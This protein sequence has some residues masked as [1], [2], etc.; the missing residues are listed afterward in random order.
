MTKCWNFLV[1][2]ALTPC[3]IRCPIT[4][5]PLIQAHRKLSP[6]IDLVELRIIYL[7][8]LHSYGHM[9]LPS[10]PALISSIINCVRHIL[11]NCYAFN[12][13]SSLDITH[14]VTHCNII[15]IHSGKF[16]SWVNTMQDALIVTSMCNE[17]Q[18]WLKCTRALT[19]PDLYFSPV[20]AD[21][22]AC[23]ILV[24]NNEKI[25]KI[26]LKGHYV[27]VYFGDYS[28]VPIY[29]YAANPLNVLHFM[30]L[31]TDPQLIEKG[32]AHEST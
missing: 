32:R 24:R 17:Y 12:G 8:F 18:E 27:I 13:T 14:R 22:L 29:I 11:N 5:N 2:P 28:S 26:S 30:H 19:V 9:V 6:Y 7:N 1:S 16:V 3:W 20:S 23:L 10:R 15:D 31:L 21:S 4:T 25:T